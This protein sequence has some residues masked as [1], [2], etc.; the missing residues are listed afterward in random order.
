MDRL[1]RLFIVHSILDRSR[2]YTKDGL[3]DLFRAM[4]DIERK[5]ELIPNSRKPKRR[6]WPSQKPSSRAASTFQSFG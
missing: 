6:P 3:N 2:D 1:T 4:E 5:P